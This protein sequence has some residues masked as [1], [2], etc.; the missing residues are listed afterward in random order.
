MDGERAQLSSVAT[1]LDDLVER[2]GDTA[3]RLHEATRDDLAADLYEVERSLEAARRRLNT[4]L[5]DLR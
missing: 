2:V 5:R 3:K 1:G 4:V